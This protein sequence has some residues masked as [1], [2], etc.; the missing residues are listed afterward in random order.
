MYSRKKRFLNPGVDWE[1][2]FIWGKSS[3][4]AGDNQCGDN[5][6]NFMVMD[7][8]ERA[9]VWAMEA[10]CNEVKAVVT[11]EESECIEWRDGELNYV[12]GA[13]TRSL[14][15]ALYVDGRYS[16]V[17]TNRVE[18]EDLRG[19]VRANVENTRYLAPDPC[20]G[21]ADA[22]VLYRGTGEDLRLTDGGYD[23]VGFEERA[24]VAEG[25]CGEM[26]HARMVSATASV[27]CVRSHTRMVM[28]NGFEGE[29][30]YTRYAVSASVSVRGEGDERQ[31]EYR[32]AADTHWGAV[33]KGGLGG[34]ALRGALA[35]IGA[36]RIEA[37]RYAVVVDCR[38]AGKLLQ[39][40]IQAVNGQAQYYK[41]SFLL[42]ARG[43]RV[44]SE[45]LSVTDTPVRVG[46]IGATYFDSDG[47][48][49]R[50]L[51][52]IEDGV[53]SNY[54][55]S[56]Y[57]GRK[58]GVDATRGATTILELG[59]GAGSQAELLRR[60]GDGVLITG[61]NGGNCNGTT[62][63]FSY[64]IEGFV[65]E[66]GVVTRPVSGMLMTGNML[67]LWR[68][69]RGVAGDAPTYVTWHTPSVWFEETRLN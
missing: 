14:S 52:L 15:L 55:I 20:R 51:P 35:R 6:L 59:G 42:D 17:D 4:F 5:V 67:S 25:L 36:G 44:G 40:L 1:A 41:N 13:R 23:G 47:C 33:V 8:A 57:M 58:M 65:V 3:I 27:E 16:V 24:L 62:G 49:A 46:M 30:G 22:G 53:L 29:S 12:G 9:M 26:V 38:V 69:L 18:G 63:D 48:T 50:D 31:E 10:G 34:E 54:L 60:M 32:F 28:S 39:P 43:E 37:G 45:W 56:Q 21:L 11:D 68:G 19:F 2:F 7:I 64:G 61:F 66:R